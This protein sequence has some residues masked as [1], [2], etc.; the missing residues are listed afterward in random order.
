MSVTRSYTVKLNEADGKHLE[1]VAAELG[2][3]EMVEP[4][5]APFNVRTFPAFLRIM[6]WRGLRDFEHHREKSMREDAVSGSDT[7][8]LDIDDDIPF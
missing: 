6:L 8:G 3:T 5:G 1:E 7:T 4:D 2:F